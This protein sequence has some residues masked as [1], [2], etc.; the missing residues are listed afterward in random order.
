M[1]KRVL[2]LLLVLVISTSVVTATVM[3]TNK[4]ENSSGGEEIKNNTFYAGYKVSVLIDEYGYSLV[5]LKTGSTVLRFNRTA[6]NENLDG[7]PV[8]SKE[9]AIGLATKFFGDDYTMVSAVEN[10]Y[11]FDIQFERQINGISVFGESGY[12]SINKMTGEIAA[13]RKMPTKEINFK[14]NV[15]VTENEALKMTNSD[16]AKLIIVPEKGVFWISTNNTV[17]DATNGKKVSEERFMESIKKLY[18]TTVDF[19]KLHGKADSSSTEERGFSILALDNDEG[20][21]GRDDWY[22][23][24]NDIAAAEESMEKDPGWDPAVVNYGIILYDYQVN[25][26]LTTY[27]AVY[28][29]GHG[30]DD[31]IGLSG[32]NWYCSWDASDNLQS[33]LFV[34]NSCN[35]GNNL[36]PTLVN[37]GVKCVIG[38]E[39]TIN[40]YLDT[41]CSDWA[42]TFWDK[43]TGN[44]DSDWYQKT[45]HTSRI[46]ANNAIAF[47]YC[48]LQVEKGD[49]DTYI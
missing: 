15:N 18:K 35:A 16:H 26:M 22:L 13:Y 30:S 28:F 7:E 38:D 45:A 5:D 48:D 9:E 20:A 43:A 6:V 17:I 3:A 40:D 33:R 47:E 11:D 21:V 8:M 49:C 34:I 2:V 4:K 23:S 42:D 41:W 37:K 25:N 19:G 36:A 46:E 10:P 14:P 32:D 31:C 24:P 39:G 1:N 12:I 27:E 44:I 29:S